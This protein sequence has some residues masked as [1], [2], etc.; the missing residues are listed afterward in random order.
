[1]PDST[2]LVLQPEMR[3]VLRTTKSCYARPQD[4]LFQEPQVASLLVCV[5][6]SVGVMMRG[7]RLRNRHDQPPVLHAFQADQSASEFLDPSGL[8]VDDEDFQARI[9]VK[10]SMTGRDHQV[11]VCVLQFGQFLGYAVGM[12]IVNQRDRA[13]HDRI[14]NCRSFGNQ[15]IANQI[16]KGLGSVRIAKPG[17]EMVEAFE[18]IRINRNSDSAEDAHD[19]SLKKQPLHGKTGE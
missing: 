14:S 6:F 19:Y 9:M 18:E 8:P 11:V 7:F 2:R 10:M 1:M 16:A 15:A 3:S 5:G 4:F 13:Y 12:M 17:D